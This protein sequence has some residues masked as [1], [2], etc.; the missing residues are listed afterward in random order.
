[1]LFRSVLYVHHDAKGAVGDRATRDRG[2]GSSLLNRD[3]DCAFMLSPHADNDD[4]A[5]LD[6]LVR[7]YPPQ[8]SVGL[9]FESCTW[10]CD[11]EVTLRPE[12]TASRRE[13]AGAWTATDHVREARLLLT[14]PMS[15]AEYLDKLITLSGAE[16]KAKRLLALVKELPDVHWEYVK[17]AGGGVVITPIL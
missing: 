17:K 4:E 1:M 14:G 8:G 3:F 15:G 7:N 6:L 5:V 11:Q 10:V 9:R 2:S 12:T 13:K 16:K